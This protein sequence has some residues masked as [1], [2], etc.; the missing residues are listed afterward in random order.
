VLCKLK[1]KE[2]AYLQMQGLASTAALQVRRQLRVLH[3]CI[4]S[5]HATTEVCASIVVQCSTAAFRA[6]DLRSDHI[7]QLAAAAAKHSRNHRWW[8][9]PIECEKG[10]AR[11]FKV[12]SATKC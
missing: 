3:L 6:K 12:E 9:A 8:A 2:I 7:L 1:R 4:C 10:L 5:D 11:P